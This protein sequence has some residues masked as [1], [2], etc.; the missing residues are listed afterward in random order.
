MRLELTGM[1]PTARLTYAV[2]D[3]QMTLTLIPTYIL[4]ST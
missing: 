4:I 3:R 2:Q 1:S